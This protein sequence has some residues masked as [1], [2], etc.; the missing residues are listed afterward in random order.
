M[1]LGR[2]VVVTDYKDLE[3]VDIVV[4]AC[5]KWLRVVETRFV[6]SGI[7]VVEVEIAQ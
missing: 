4:E 2:I 7:A 6:L 1:T 5:L 3:R